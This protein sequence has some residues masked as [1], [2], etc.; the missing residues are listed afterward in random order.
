MTVGDASDLLTF[1][2]ERL[3]HDPEQSD[4]IHDLLAFLAEEM[5]RLNK[6]KR[7][8]QKRYL[9][10]LVASLHIQPDRD[11]NAGLDAL[12]GKS[13]LANYPGDYQKGE[14]PL[15]L[16]DLLDI[17]RKNHARLAVNLN[18]LTL[19]ERL[20]REYGASLECVLPLKERLA[21]TD[22]LIDQIVYQ[23]YGLTDAEI[24]IVEGR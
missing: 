10:G 21:R 11:G 23:L 14:A 18:D 24:A 20:R 5:I 13:K 4:V 7:A 1:A 19:V 6:E 22:R 15:A 8:E 2:T 9:D 16:D 3:S 17:L 12:T